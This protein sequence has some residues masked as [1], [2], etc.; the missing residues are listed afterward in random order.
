MVIT[1]HIDKWDVMRVL[2]DNGSQIE[3]LFLSTFEQMGFD[4]KQLK[5]ASKPLYSFGGRKIEQ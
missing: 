2:V 1:A 3:I 5:E 4:R